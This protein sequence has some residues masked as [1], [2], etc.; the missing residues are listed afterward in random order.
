MKRA[1]GRNRNTAAFAEK[2]RCVE[3]A[4]YLIEHSATVRATAQHFHISKSTVHKDISE[5]LKQIHPTLYR[6]AHEV[7]MQNKEERH[8][9]GGKATQDKYRTLRNKKTADANGKT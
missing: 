4:E 3:L 6:Q 8:I 1:I 5:R 9:R 2:E 7:L